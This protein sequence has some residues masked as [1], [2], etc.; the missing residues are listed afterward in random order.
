MLNTVN[1][2]IILTRTPHLSGGVHVMLS[3]IEALNEMGYDIVI[4]AKEKPRWNTIS[5]F[6]TASTSTISWQPLA[7]KG[8]MPLQ[9]Q[10]PAALTK[11]MALWRK[12]L[13]INVEGDAL[14]LPAH[15][16]Y[17]HF[18][19]F[20]LHTKELIHIV[21]QYKLGS[22][23]S[24]KFSSILRT[25]LLYSP[26][27]KLTRLILANS[28]FTA[29]VLRNVISDVKVEVLY[30]PL[31]SPFNTYAKQLLNGSLGVEKRGNYVVTISA[32][33]PGKRLEDVLFLA[34]KIKYA[35]FLIVGRLGKFTAYYRKL[36][37]MVKALNLENVVFL[38]NLPREQLCELLLKS[39]IYLHP[40]RFEH[41]GIS[42]IEAM[43]AGLVPV[44]HRS[45]GPWE[46]ILDRKQGLYGY[47]YEDIEEAINYIGDLLN[48]ESLRLKVAE[49]TVRRA[50][51]F[52]EEIFRRRFKTIVKMLSR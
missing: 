2:V 4:M 37:M 25:K 12:S 38:P 10:L 11:I 45:G 31:R 49:R 33:W 22:R 29:N 20:A 52:D 42:I 18:P 9:P 24:S 48:N 46:D 19:M 26:I 47:A 16:T 8:C 44:V 41:F 50:L 6:F 13:L 7:F 23:L 32:F 15:I 51:M 1:K 27:L 30:P 3:I 40:M 43:A 5:K 14:P 36:K 34:K 17:V 28:K 39:K 35:K 21:E